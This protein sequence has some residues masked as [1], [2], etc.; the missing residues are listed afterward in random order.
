M[1]EYVVVK[2]VTKSELAQRFGDA[3]EKAMD[4]METLIDSLDENIAYKASSF[5]LEQVNGKARQKIEEVRSVN[6]FVM[7]PDKLSMEE[8]ERKAMEYAGKE[9]E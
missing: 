8:W 2:G 4:K 9:R 3:G 6:V 1:S 7:P 5:V